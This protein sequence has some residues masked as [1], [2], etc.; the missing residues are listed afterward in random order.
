LILVL[1]FVALAIA[2]VMLHR[3]S[4]GGSADIGRARHGSR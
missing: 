4:G 2:I 3:P 1:V